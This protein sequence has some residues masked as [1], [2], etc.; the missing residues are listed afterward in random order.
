VVKGSDHLARPQTAALCP[1]IDKLVSGAASGRKK[2]KE[3]RGEV[4]SEGLEERKRRG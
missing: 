4:K 2:M 3:L 1:L